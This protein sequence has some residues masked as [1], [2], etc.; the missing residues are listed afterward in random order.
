MDWLTFFSNV[1]NSLAWPITVIII[2]LILRQP[3]SNLLQLIQHLR[4]QGLEVEFGQ[5]M[6]ALALEAQKLLPPVKGSLGSEKQLLEQKVEL[7]R[8]SPRAVVLE[9]WLQ[10][11]QAAVDAIHRHG[12]ELKSIELHSP[13]MLGKTLEE[14]GILDGSTPAIY[15]QL[16]NLRNAAAHASDFSFSA[17]SAL[18]YAELAARLTEILRKA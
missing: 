16:R 7:A 14:A 5:K 15:H 12:I 10:L 1:I 8:V 17:D 4:F 18:E 2:V 11:E 3:L 6:Q 9:S 13:L